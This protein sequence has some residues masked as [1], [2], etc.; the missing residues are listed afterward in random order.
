MRA[1]HPKRARKAAPRFPKRDAQYTF[2][3]VP[4]YQRPSCWLAQFTF[5][6]CGGRL[7]AA[8]LIPK[9]QIKRVLALQTIDDTD[10]YLMLW[11]ARVTRPACVAHH[12]ALDAACTIRIPR[13][14]IPAETE[15]YA[16]EL[17][18]GWWLER[19][20]GPRREAA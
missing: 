6:P 10:A 17:G 16:G 7:Q 3:I 18:L 15:E 8:H 5:T 9:Q 14:D 13:T 4:D 19:T 1:L 20:Y 11:D 12:V 2:G